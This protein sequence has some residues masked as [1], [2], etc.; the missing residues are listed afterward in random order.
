M[1]KTYE[2]YLNDYKAAREVQQLLK[3]YSS[4]E[5]YYEIELSSIV[6]DQKELQ[7]LRTEIYMDTSLNPL[8]KRIYP[9]VIKSYYSYITDEE[10]PVHKSL[11]K[12][13]SANH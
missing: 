4:L 12:G 10:L 9:E 1:K 13:Q 5:N 3:G 2:K 8:E 6:T 7:L 11:T